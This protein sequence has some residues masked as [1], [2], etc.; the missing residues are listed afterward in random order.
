MVEFIR[1]D[2][3]KSDEVEALLRPLRRWA[4][5]SRIT[6]IS[7]GALEDFHYT[8]IHGKIVLRMRTFDLDENKTYYIYPFRESFDPQ[9]IRELKES[10]GGGDVRLMASKEDLPFYRDHFELKLPVIELPNRAEYLY[11]R[12]DLAELPGRKYQPKRNHINN[13]LRKYGEYLYEPLDEKHVEGCKELLKWWIYERFG[14]IPESY[15]ERDV[16]LYYLDNFRRLGMRGGTVTAS[17]RVVAFCLGFEISDDTFNVCLEKADR[18]MEGAYTIINRD[19]S[20]S[21]PE[22]YTYINREDDMG[23]EGLRRAK[24]SYHPTELLR[25]YEIVI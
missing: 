8:F 4:W 11:L 19:F 10:V 16:D 1:L 15:P 7:W 13:F 21:L 14:Y 17:G 22:K 9:V 18:D 24:I 6:L 25:K 20:R 12:S 2:E 23:D 3:S 5:L